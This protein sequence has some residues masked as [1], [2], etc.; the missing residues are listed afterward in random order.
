VIQIRPAQLET[1]ERN[2]LRQF[3]DEMVVHLKKFHP[4]HASAAGEEGLRRMIRTG[5]ERAKA[6]GFTLRGPVQFYLEQ[7]MIYGHDY[8]TDPL[9]PWAGRALGS[10]GPNELDRADRMHELAL[11]YHARAVGPNGEK[12]QAA[13]RRLLKDPVPTWLSGNL[14][15]AGV[16]ARLREVY[17]EKCAAAEPNAL[18]TVIGV[19]RCKALD[20]GLPASTGG[21]VFAALSVALGH[22]YLMDPMYPW[23]AEILKETEGQLSEQRVGKLAIRAMGFL[24]AV[25]AEHEKG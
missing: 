16:E 25:L 22:G 9:L 21:L 11:D 14:S 6:Y 10:G 24:S 15:E 13:I 19:S 7:M 1:F 8:D 3:E 23:V 2:A 20:R 5:I 17:P 12:E 4:S 18:R